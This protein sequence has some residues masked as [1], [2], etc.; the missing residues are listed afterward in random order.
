V[1]LPASALIVGQKGTQVALVG[2]G[3]T[4]QLRTVTVGRDNGNLVEISAG[5]KPLDAVIDSPPD[6]LQAGDPVRIAQAKAGP[7]DAGK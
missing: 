7:A 3:G 5:L 4:A 6:S 2:P 1:Q